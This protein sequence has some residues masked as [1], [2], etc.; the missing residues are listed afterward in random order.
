MKYISLILLATIFSFSGF[1][2]NGK[3]VQFVGGARS[4]I[5]NSNFNAEG[6]STTVPRHSGGNALMDLGFKINPNENTEILGMV[7]IN[8]EFG[9]F[10]GG[11]VTFD[12]RQLYVRGVAGGIVRYQIGNINY[13]LTPYTFYNH[14]QDILTSSIGTMQIKE[15]VI[16][17]ESFYKDNTWR[18]QGASANFGLL[19]PKVIQEIEFNGFITRLNPT[20]FASV[21]ERLYGG[22]NTVIKQSKHLT[23]GVNHVSV[24]D[25]SG[26]AADTNLY[27]NNVSS[28]TYDVQ[29]KND[30]CTFGLDGESGIS[31][32]SQSDYPDDD[33]T[34]YFVHARI[35]LNLIK[36]GLK[37]N[38]GYMDNGPDFR[39]FGAQSKRVNF[40]QENTFYNRYT[41][42][43]VIRPI[44]MYDMYN[45]PGIYKD[46]ITV[47]VM[48]Y[49]PLI[50]TTLPY[51]IASFNRQ[52]GYIG[53]N[54]ADKKKI[55]EAEG[56][57]YFLSEI[58]GQGTSYLKSFLMGDIQTQL[59]A[60]KIWSGDKEV[61]LQLG[62]IHQQSTRNGDFA[63]QN[64]DL[65]STAVNLGIEGEIVDQLYLMGNVFALC[66]LGN[67]QIPSR[68]SDDMI[69][70]YQGYEVEGSEV[71]ISGGLRFNFSKKIYLAGMY[72]WNSYNFSNYDPYSIQQVSLFY[73]M[74]F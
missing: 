47:G 14:N 60:E 57:L 56:K 32:T 22:G 31:L 15:D 35:Y 45:D 71:N 64:V 70:N 50:N 9:G 4:L 29:F 37:L 13:K 25:L 54:Y 19:F 44:S 67:D 24:F 10:W 28:L 55:V 23:L 52:G 62:M 72:E 43:Q 20:N 1:A 34:D 74:K 39:S 33:L 7:R 49:N 59:H 42:A 12:V 5:T 26:T 51:G 68:D 63:F 73:V 48:D 40:N 6:D 18:Q 36:P 8:N 69:I 58:R 38:I 41:N 46:G 16:N 53:V 21:L 3:K 2:Q 17:Y 65:N 27:K 66:A 61:T 30:N 11:G